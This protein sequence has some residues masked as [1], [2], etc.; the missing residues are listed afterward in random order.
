MHEA[1]GRRD[2]QREQQADD[3]DSDDDQ[4]EPPPSRMKQRERERGEG[5]DLHRRAG[6][7][8]QRRQHV[9]TVL[10]R[11]VGENDQRGHVCIARA[12][13]ERSEEIREHEQRGEH[14]T[15]GLE[16]A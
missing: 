15:I 4:R 3:R 8:R 12:G 2:E 9:M 7:D 13:L 6:D 1:R 14:G 11:C 10:Q 5:K 16:D